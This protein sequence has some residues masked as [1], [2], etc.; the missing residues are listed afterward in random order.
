[1]RCWMVLALMM[2]Y[3][4]PC[5]YE[6][7]RET[8][9]LANR[10]Q[11][12]PLSRLN[13]G[14]CPRRVRLELFRAVC[15][16]TLSKSCFSAGCLCWAIRL[17]ASVRCS[18]MSEIWRSS[19]HQPFWIDKLGV[20]LWYCTDQRLTES[21]VAAQDAHVQ[22]KTP[23]ASEASKTT[24]TVASVSTVSTWASGV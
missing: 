17:S 5:K 12:A 22:K 20:T 7:L 6:N 13:P 24:G 14:R 15:R 18:K 19:K 23:T 16:F 3:D 10:L 8:L 11:V 9:T 4:F 1:M 2:A 21:Y